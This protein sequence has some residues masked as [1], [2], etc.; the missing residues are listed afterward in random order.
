MSSPSVALADQ[1]VNKTATRQPG[2]ET[3]EVVNFGGNIRFTPGRY[4][5]PHSENEV[6]EILD[7]HAGEQIRVV[8][9]RHAWS[10]AI[11]SPDVIVDLRHLKHLEI[12]KTA[13]GEI[14]GGE[15]SVSV[16]GGCPIKCL[17]DE[18][19]ARSNSTLP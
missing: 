4:Y 6:L 18:L 2:A 9:S 19:H 1:A 17:L 3:R 16:G 12:T 8:G 5:M 7:R 11:V 14:P 15:I 10:E 13:G